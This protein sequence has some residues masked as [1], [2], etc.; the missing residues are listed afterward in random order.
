MSQFNDPFCIVMGLVILVMLG[1]LGMGL[2]RKAVG[3]SE[4]KPP[5]PGDSGDKCPVCKS[6]M[7]FKD[8]PYSH[9]QKVCTGGCG[10]TE[11]V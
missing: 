10:Y 5:E 4:P 1:A 6:G 11:F 8:H 7:V 9:N 3:Q 2:E